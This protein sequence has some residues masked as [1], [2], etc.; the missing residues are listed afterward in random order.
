MESYQLGGEENGRKGTG[1]KKHNWQIENRQ[2]EVKNSTGNGE[3]KELMCMTHGHELRWGDAG[4]RGCTAQRGMKRGKWDNCDS[5]IN[6]IYFKKEK[7]NFNF[8]S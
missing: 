5:I 1:N 3:V 6:K 7:K 2:E 8:K 4:G